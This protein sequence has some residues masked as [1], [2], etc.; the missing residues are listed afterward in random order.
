MEL[1]TFLYLVPN[2]FF[3]LWIFRNRLRVPKRHAYILI[4]VLAILTVPVMAFLYSPSSPFQ[5]WALGYSALYLFFILVL[6]ILG[7][8]GSCTQ[9]LFVCLLLCCYSDDTNLLIVMLERLFYQGQ[10]HFG[11][12]TY[13]VLH[14]IL[15]VLTFP[16]L[17]LFID[18]MLRPMIET[19]KNMP[20]WRMLWMIPAFFY[21]LYR[22]NIFPGKYTPPSQQ[23]EGREL[24]SLVWVFGTFFCL[25]LILKMLSEVTKNIEL[26]ERLKMSDMQLVLQKEQ[27]ETLQAGIE[28]SRQARHD[29]HHHLLVMKR[30]LDNQDSS[31]LERYLNQYLET[32]QTEDQP[33]V[34]ENYAVNAIAQ[35]YSGLARSSGIEVALSLE[36]PRDL[37]VLESDICIVIGNLFENAVEACRQQKTTV[38]FIQVKMAVV[39]KGM[40]AISVKNSYD[41]NIRRADGAFLST[42]HPGEGIGTE[43]VKRIAD[44]Y[45][46]STRFHYENG[47][48]EAS[49]LLVH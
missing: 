46:G 40:I 37:P 28:A 1:N 41:G 17:R 7:T 47:I 2:I 32:F 45:H 30:Y 21:I 39:G 25:F 24:L 5:N 29:L 43:S 23:S 3:Y 48:F 4:A 15:L 19:G 11:E 31:E 27:Y 22:V 33:P 44:R 12:H 10:I 38:R 13:L 36:L 9:I 14:G 8:D 20:Y 35:H 34:C 16:L 49:V 6:C 18:R 42:K 26:R